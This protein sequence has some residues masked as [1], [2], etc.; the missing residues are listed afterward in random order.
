[1]K[2]LVVED[3]EDFREISRLELEK[4]RI[5]VEQASTYYQELLY[6]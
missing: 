2:I 5:L 3:N 1:M 4:E 6:S